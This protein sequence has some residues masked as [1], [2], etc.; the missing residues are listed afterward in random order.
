MPTQTEPS[1]NHRT[2]GVSGGSGSRTGGGAGT[3]TALQLTEPLEKRLRRWMVRG[4]IAAFCIS[5]GIHVVMLLIAAIWTM[6][7]AH[8]GGSTGREAGEIDLAIM[9]EAELGAIEEAALDAGSPSIGDLSEADV[10][11]DALDANL[12]SVESAVGAAIGDI[13]DQMSGAGGDIGGVSGLGESGAGGGAAKFFGVEATGTRFAYIVDVSGS[14]QGPKLGAMKI[15]L[16]ESIDAL[17]EHMQF[18]VS[19]FS[20]DAMLIGD[21]EKWT[22]ASDNGKK[23]AR[24]LI[25]ELPSYGGT[26]PL[27]SFQKAFDLKP[28]P[29]AIYFMTDGQFAEDVAPLVANMNKRGKRVPIH[30]IA[31]DIQDQAVEVMMKKIAAESG[32]EFTSVPLTRSH[33]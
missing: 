5:L 18:F 7:I 19:P 9:S 10:S 4:S 21:K 33:R 20:S 13:A 27:P 31:F 14:M 28:R 1:D 11:P 25:M 29:D 26:V 12:P 22:I 8:A 16:I 23:W 3:T 15:E 6:G 24:G 2:N 17:L 32:G 30:C